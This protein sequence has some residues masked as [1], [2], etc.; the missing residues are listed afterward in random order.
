VTTATA[1]EALQL[2]DFAG[3]LAALDTDAVRDPEWFELRAHAAYGNGDY[4]DAVAAWEQLHSLHRTA[5]ERVPAARAAAMTA[6]FLLIE[7]GLL[8][9]VRGWIRRAERLLE[10]EAT[11]PVHALI[12]AVRGY[13]RFFSGD[14]P[15]ATRFATDAIALGE[16]FDVM[17]AVAIGRTAVARIAV[18]DGDIDDGLA[19]LDEVAALLMSGE[20]DDLTTGMMLCELV[21]AAQAMMRTDLAREWTD[22]MAQWSR[23]GAFGSMGGRCRVHQAELLRLSGPGEAAERAALEACEQLRPWMRR[24]FGWPLVELGLARLRRGD[25]AGAEESFAA[26]AEHAWPAHPGLGLLHLERGDVAEAASQIARAIAHPIDAPSKELPPFGDLRLVPLLD[27]QSEIAL[28]GADETTAIAAAEQLVLTAGRYRSPALTAVAEL[29]TARAALLG[30]DP[31]AAI[32]AANSAV[33]AFV[34]LEA[35]FDVARTHLVLVDAHAAAGNAAAAGAALAAARSEFARYGAGHRV[36][37]IDRRLR[38]PS[39]SQVARNEASPLRGVLR[40][41]G[42]MLIVEL[43]GH[44]AHVKDLKGLR[45]IRR[46]AGEP[47]REFHVL[48]LIGVETGTLRTARPA[49]GIPMLDA[50]ARAAYQRRLAEIDDDIAEATQLNDLGRVDK[51]QADRQYLIA[52]LTRAVG[53][54]GRVRRTAD[55]AERARTA[56]ARTLR[57]AIGQLAIQH[58]PAAEHFRHT[59]RTGT[60]CSYVPDPLASLTWDL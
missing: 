11:T 13:E 17:P 18:V 44:T 30:G 37:A 29:A 27:A 10:G 3:A 25:L 36:A 49:D 47:G 53:L 43:S 15:S 60:Y 54:G 59:I 33:A 16:Q 8:S 35:S 50:T 58:P 20:V 46:M 2:R 1:R 40:P 24:E 56:V 38:Q 22:V 23:T 39:Q 14:L 31:Q 32:V 19:Q 26:A 7:A 9:P 42:P 12:A 48:D 51:A 57:Y 34:T 5:G 52:E 6:M 45:Y 4:E 21:C 55:T 41:D 28:A